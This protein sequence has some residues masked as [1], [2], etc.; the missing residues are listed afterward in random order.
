MA[1][2]FGDRL[3]FF[4][5]TRFAVLETEEI[6]SHHEADQPSPPPQRRPYNKRPA[7]PPVR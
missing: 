7:H 3:N 1:G 2:D 5:L 6:G 4:G